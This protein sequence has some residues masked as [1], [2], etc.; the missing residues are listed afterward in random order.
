MSERAQRKREQNKVSQRKHRARQAARVAELEAEVSFLRQKLLESRCRGGCDLERQ[1]LRLKKEMDEA[2]RIG[3]SLQVLLAN[4]VKMSGGRSLPLAAINLEKKPSR[5]HGD[6]LNL[7][8]VKADPDNA[9]ISTEINLSPLSVLHQTQQQGLEH[10]SNCGLRDQDLLRLPNP[11][12][13]EQLLPEQLHPLL[14]D[15][16]LPPLHESPNTNVLNRQYQKMPRHPIV[17]SQHQ[18]SQQ[19]ESQEV[20]QQPNRG[21]YSHQSIPSQNQVISPNTN[22]SLSAEFEL[23]KW[24]THPIQNFWTEF[25]YPNPK[26]VYR[27]SVQQQMESI[28]MNFLRLVVS[29]RLDMSRADFMLDSS[30]LNLFATYA[31][32]YLEVIPKLQSFTIALGGT[33]WLCG[34]L[35]LA[36]YSRANC[37]SLGIFIGGD[38]SL[39]PVAVELKNRLLFGLEERIHVGAFEQVLRLHFPCQSRSVLL[40]EDPVNVVVPTYFKPTVLQMSLIREGIS[41]DLACNFVIWPEFRDSII[42]HQLSMGTT[43]TVDVIDELM[44]N[45]VLEVDLKLF[46]FKNLVLIVADTSKFEKLIQNGVTKPWFWK[47]T[48]SY[49]KRYIGIVPNNII[50]PI[51]DAKEENVFVF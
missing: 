42:R 10:L 15:F 24:T 48:R 11:P 33:K 22:L 44:D 40:P 17:P 30:L 2:S 29:L 18:H 50:S 14:A 37:K 35:L 34:Q 12:L 41:Y 43:Q 47:V 23:D 32:K 46:Y 25:L 21:Y 26:N 38:Q 45:V 16:P 13:P 4:M 39:D 1:L 8:L 27:T 19:Y 5:P 31:E 9:E 36:V 3:G 7:E 28:E 49:G 51:D 20:Q 6:D